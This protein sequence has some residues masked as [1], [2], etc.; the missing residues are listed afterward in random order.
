MTVSIKGDKNT[1]KSLAGAV[2]SAA[3]L[4]ACGGGSDALSP[5]SALQMAAQ[6]EQ[7]NKSIA[8]AASREP[9]QAKA[10]ALAPTS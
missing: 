5:R 10:R 3:L 8:A 9:T 6:S 2:A 4:S 1:I 7:V